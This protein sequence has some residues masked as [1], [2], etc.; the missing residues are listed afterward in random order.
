ML[1]CLKG[2][3]DDTLGVDC[4]ARMGGLQFLFFSSFFES[5]K[6]RC[7]QKNKQNLRG[8]ST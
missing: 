5:L 7:R 6:K 4:A 1:A 8:L 3:E 2:S